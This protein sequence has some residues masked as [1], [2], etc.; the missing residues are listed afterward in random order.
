MPALDARPRSTGF[1]IALLCQGA[2]R[3]REEKD[4]MSSARRKERKIRVT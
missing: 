4:R 2:A 3:G 1:I